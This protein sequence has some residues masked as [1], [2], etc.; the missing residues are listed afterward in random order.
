MALLRRQ[1]QVVARGSGARWSA[2]T[3]GRR[4]RGV[5]RAVGLGVAAVGTLMALSG[6][7]VGR[8]FGGFGWPEG[9]TPQARQMYGLW[10]G[11]VVAALIV[12][13]LV[14]GL[15]FWCVVRYRKTS[16]ELPPQTRYNMPMEILYTVAPFLVI[17]IL[18]Y[19]TAVTQNYVDYLSPKP[20]TTIEVVGFQWNWKFNY[21]DEDAKGPDGQPISTVGASDYIPVLVVPTNEKILF[22]ET[23]NDVIHSFW[24]PDLLFKRDVMPG[25]PDNQKNR[26][27]VTIEKEGPYV[28]RCA[29]LCGIYHSAMNFEVRAVSPEKYKQFIQARK[30]G[31]S[32]P[33]ALGAIGFD[34]QHRFATTT[35]PFN[36]DPASRSAS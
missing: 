35:H 36:T 4:R 6:C 26:F 24:V 33:E 1:E 22:I 11:S 14:W 17:A 18:F 28:G 32:T 19:Y 25:L 9:V 15:I 34:E 8:T 29:E 10:V 16:D 23:S 12:G 7:S 30:A 3:Q 2:G 20:D 13:V 27:E 5:A 21:L 31:M